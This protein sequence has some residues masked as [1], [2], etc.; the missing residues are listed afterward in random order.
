MKAS[1]YS[2][3]TSQLFDRDDF[4]A[5]Y[6][7]NRSPWP[8]PDDEAGLFNEV[9]NLLADVLPFANSV[10]VKTC[11]GNEVPLVLPN[12]V[13]DLLKKRGLD[14]ESPDVRR[15]IYEGIFTRIE[16]THPLDFY[17]FWTPERWTWN[18]ETKEDLAKAIR[19][20]DAAIKAYE[21][22]KPSFNLAT[23]GWVLGPMSD[24]ALFDK[25]LPKSVAFSCINRHVGWE[26]IDPAFVRINEREKWA[27]PWLEDDGA[28][29]TTQFGVREVAS[30]PLHSRATCGP[31]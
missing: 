22:I 5:E 20:F 28:L 4:G 13:I 17:W 23:C 27:I 26:P 18:P 16:K 29:I 14:P 25:Y 6:M 21:A 7:R 8:K 15:R 24:R 31:P 30:C 9:G 1:D 2:F 3:G 11:V 12:Q 10:G 19:D